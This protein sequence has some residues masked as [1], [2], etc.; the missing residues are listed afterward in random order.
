MGWVES[1]SGMIW[2]LSLAV[3][4]AMTV[5]MLSAWAFGVARSNGGWTDVFWTFGTGATVAVAALFPLAGNAR[6]ALVA[7]LVAVWAIRLGS[8]IAVRVAGHAHEDPRYA[9]FRADWGK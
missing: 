1:G 2:V 3:L 9:K 4:V 7:A 5:V 6:Q 8:Y